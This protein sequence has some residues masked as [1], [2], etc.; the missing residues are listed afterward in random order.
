LRGRRHLLQRLT[1]GEPRLGGETL[2]L[3]AELRGEL[4]LV[5]G[6]QGAPVEREVAG[7][8]RVDGPADDVGDDEV[9]GVDPR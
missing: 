7:R 3:P 4:A 8:E 1:R 5:A 9:A 6:D 2:D